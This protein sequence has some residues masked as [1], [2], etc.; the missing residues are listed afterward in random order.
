MQ[1]FNEL[2]LSYYYFDVNTL[3]AEESNTKKPIKLRAGYNNIVGSLTDTSSLLV[4]TLRSVGLV[5]FQWTREL[6]L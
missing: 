2:K 4:K 6:K 5:Y 3:A 1:C